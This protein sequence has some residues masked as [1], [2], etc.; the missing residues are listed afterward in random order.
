MSRPRSRPVCTSRIGKAPEASQLPTV[1]TH[2]VAALSIGTVLL[3]RAAKAG[4]WGAGALCAM[5]PD[6]DVAAK[7]A[8]ELG[9]KTLSNSGWNVYANMEHLRSRRIVSGFASSVADYV[10]DPG[11][12]PATDALLARSIT[13]GVGVVD[14][15][16]GS[17]F[18]ISV[19]ATS[20][21]IER[22]AKEFSAT[23]ERHL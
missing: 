17:A 10:A 2:A 19:R 7:V 9:T 3:P 23:V 16:I 5:L 1:F 14:P 15:G 20:S 18:G 6:A 11:S 22:V 21:D 4:V 8:A 13:L 12:L